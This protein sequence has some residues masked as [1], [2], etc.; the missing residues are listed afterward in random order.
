MALPRDAFDYVWLIDLPEERWNSFPGLV[1]IWTGGHSG[2]LYRVLP[3]QAGSATRASETP[4]GS[5]PRTAA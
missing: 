3:D 5:K 2:I 4:A 1:P